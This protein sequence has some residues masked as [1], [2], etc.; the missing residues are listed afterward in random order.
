[1][2][3]LVGTARWLGAN[4]DRWSGTVVLVGQPAEEAIGGAKAMLADGLYERFPRPDAALALHVTH[5]QEV[6]TVGYTSGPGGS[7]KLDFAST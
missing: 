4:R 1:M 7:P 3:C 6:G 2:T 5:D